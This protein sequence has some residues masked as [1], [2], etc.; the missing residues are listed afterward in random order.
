MTSPVEHLQDAIYSLQFEIIRLE[1]AIA[2]LEVMPATVPYGEQL[3][4]PSNEPEKPEP[5]ASKPPIYVVQDDH[6]ECEVCGDT[7]HRNGIGPH[8][9]KHRNDADQ[10]ATFDPDVARANAAAAI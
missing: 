10:P 6:V 4:E 8:R 1:E 3:A 9:R 7:F 5:V 2:Y